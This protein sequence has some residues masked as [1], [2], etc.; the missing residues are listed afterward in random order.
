MGRRLILAVS[1]LASLLPPAFA[2]LPLI[3]M[4][5]ERKAA[6]EPHVVARSSAVFKIVAAALLSGGRVKRHAEWY[7][8]TAAEAAGVLNALVFFGNES[9]DRA[10]VLNVTCRALRSPTSREAAGCDP[11]TLPAR[12]EPKTRGHGDSYL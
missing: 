3:N 5:P 4:S 10:L 11:G 12:T 6:L 2:S 8:S 9:T 7:T 1:L